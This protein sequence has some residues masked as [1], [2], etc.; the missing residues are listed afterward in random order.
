MGLAVTVAMAMTTGEGRDVAPRGTGVGVNDRA[1][2]FAA[3][4]YDAIEAMA[5]SVV[6]GDEVA[7]RRLMV[8]LDPMVRGEARRQRQQAVRVGLDDEVEVDDLEQEARLELWR[9]MAEYDPA[10]G[11]ALAFFRMR[12]RSRLRKHVESLSRRRWPG[13]RISWEDGG[14]EAVA[15]ALGAQMARERAVA[16][17]R[18]ATRLDVLEAMGDLLPRHQR[19]LA[20]MHW[21][22]V[23]QAT[24]AR[25]MGISEPAVRQLHRRA[26]DALRT[27]LSRWHYFA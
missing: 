13:R 14:A 20:F 18:S 11:P 19:V 23:D 5:A 22:Q 27:R 6:T 3:A 12:L 8:A 10:R 17:G 4:D 9:L 24:I 2:R 7:R 26:L 15:E 25:V 1:S 21:R 16:E